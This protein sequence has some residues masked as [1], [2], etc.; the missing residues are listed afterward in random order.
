MNQKEIRCGQHG[1]SR[2]AFVCQHLRAGAGLGWYQADPIDYDPDD[3][4]WDCL[5]A[6]CEDCEQLRIKENGWNQATDDFMKIVAVC[7]EC[8][9]KFKER[10][11]RS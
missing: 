8:A 4:F 7:E 11:Q 10:N 1:A 5:N 3:P 9:L 6:W 2:P